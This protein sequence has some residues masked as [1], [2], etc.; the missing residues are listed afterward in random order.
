[1]A[2][3]LAVSSR[4]VIAVPDIDVFALRSIAAASLALGGIRPGP[5]FNRGAATQS[6]TLAPVP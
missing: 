1:M 6:S 4:T 5:S 3:T 2:S